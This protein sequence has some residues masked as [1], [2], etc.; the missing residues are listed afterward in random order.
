MTDTAAFKWR[1]STRCGSE[2]AC[3]EVAFVANEVLVR[4]SRTDDG[5]T[6]KF[7]RAEWLAFLAGV[8]DDEFT[9]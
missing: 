4:S 2:A 6:L 9:D 3:V 1:R 5:P 7:T 8:R